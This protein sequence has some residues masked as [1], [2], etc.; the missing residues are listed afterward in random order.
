MILYLLKFKPT[1]AVPTFATNGVFLFY[2]P[3][4]LK[5]LTVLEI[6]GALAHEILHCVLQHF[7]RDSGR[8]KKLYNIAADLVINYLLRLQ[9]F[10]LPQYVLYEYMGVHGANKSADQCY[11]E[12]AALSGN[13]GKS[14][15]NDDGTPGT[16]G[17]PDDG[18]PGTPD[19]GTPGIPD[20]SEA[21][22]CTILEPGMDEDGNPMDSEFNEAET[23]LDWE[24]AVESATKEAKRVGQMPGALEEIIKALLRPQV[25]WVA[26]TRKWMFND[27]SVRNY[28]KFKKRWLSNDVYLPRKFNK[29]LGNGAIVIDS[30][31]SCSTAQEQGFCSEISSILSAFKP[32]EI[33]FFSCDTQ[34]HEPRTLTPK[35]LPLNDLAIHGRGGT[36]FNPAFQYIESLDKK[37][38]WLIYFTDLD[39]NDNLLPEDPGYPVLWV[40]NDTRKTG[41]F[42]KTVYIT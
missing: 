40:C 1:S 26:A 36:A 3:D 7:N 14:K 2:N 10:I 23:T 4:H 18:T 8:D 42:G 15:P 21:C 9:G 31:G 24:M 41:P 28:N 19:D 16:P 20:H 34:V 33:L 27:N 6:T 37:P 29:K 25:N 17:T 5:T 22:T 39:I 12:L 30:S 32:D 11:E 35:D 38:N 13:N